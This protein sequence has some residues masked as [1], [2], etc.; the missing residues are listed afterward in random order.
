MAITVRY[1]ARMAETM[2][3]L[4]ESLDLPAGV[5]DGEGL[6]QWLA[7][8]NPRQADALLDPSNRVGV[9]NR[10]GDRDVTISDG[11]EIAILPPFSGG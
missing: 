2:G 11:D 1:F 5:T 3:C 10:L 9:N 6:I 7:T 4:E 8:R